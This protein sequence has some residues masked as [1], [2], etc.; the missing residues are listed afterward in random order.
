MNLLITEGYI[1]NSPK[2]TITN[3]SYGYN[4]DA[5]NM[6]YKSKENIQIF[7]Y[8]TIGKSI[9]YMKYY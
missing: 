8:V 4:N 9:R 5:I 7:K 6:H 3:K 1:L 2:H